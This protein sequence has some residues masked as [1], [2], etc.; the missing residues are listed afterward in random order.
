MGL[1]K[2]L[3]G[4][5]PSI[6]EMLFN[7]KN[8]GQIGEYLTTYAL[9][10][11]N[12]S[13]YFKIINNACLPSGFKL[14]EIDII[15]IHEKG[16]FVFEN[17]NYSGWIFGSRNQKQ[18]T[19]SLI[20]KEKHKFYNPILQNEGHCKTVANFLDIAESYLISYIVFSNRCE[21]MSIPDDEIKL[22][23]LK[24]DNLLKTLREDLDS[25]LVM[26]SHEKVDLLYDKFISNSV[27]DTSKIELQK[28]TA[29]KI[30]NNE[31]CPY[32]G[33]DL[34]IKNGKYGRFYACSKYPSCRYTKNI[35][36]D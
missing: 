18:W 26:F 17:K 11:N 23:I 3:K 24:R 12:I 4:E 1:Y 7:Y 19:Q 27:N 35:K 8:V 25:R 13:G 30:K 29:I 6:I 10:N 16:V 36:D 5:E 31:I 34:V 14:T 9:S 32:C 33:N 21:L 22:K 15:M 28:E 2:Y 20:N